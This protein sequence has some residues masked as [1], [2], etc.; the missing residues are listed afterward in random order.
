[1]SKLA[2]STQTPN[3]IHM[4]RVFDAPA[5]LV[6][7]AMMTPDLMK[8]WM[9]NSRS[10][11]V[12]VEVDARVGGQ[13]RHVYRRPDGVEFAFR[14]VFRELGEERVVQT[15]SFE[16]QE[17]ES[18]ITTTL[19]EQGGKTTLHIVMSFASRQVRDM[20]VATGM[21]NGAAESYDNLE[22]LLPGLSSGDD[23]R[24]IPAMLAR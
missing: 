19:T 9:G 1:M 20:V 10:V 8:R 16:G 6:R 21:A 5:R 13:Y 22:A 4:T 24:P 15:E 2:V 11:L 3:E 7:K 17:G 23:S 12:S 14:G 18:T